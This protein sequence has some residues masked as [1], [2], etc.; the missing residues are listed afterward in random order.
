MSPMVITLALLIL[1]VFV[2][3]V[4]ALQ[5]AHKAA[6]RK[7]NLT[8]I[9]GHAKIK[10]RDGKGRDAQNRRRA[11]IAQKLKEKEPKDHKSGTPTMAQRLQMAG[12]YGTSV[13][14]FWIY[15]LIC[16][17]F[18]MVL[19]FVLK[20]PAP[21]LTVPM[22]GLV[23]LL[24]LPRLFLHRKI[25]SRQQKFLQEFADALEAMVRLLRAGMP[26]S[27]AIR[28]SS[29]EFTGPVGEEMSRIYDA[30]KIG[31]SLPE[32]VQ[33][34]ARRMPI[35]EMQMFA[36]GVTIQQQTG[37]SLSEILTN[38][39]NVI[40]ARFR[41]RRKIQALSAEAKAS[42]MI[43]GSLPFLVGLGM[44]FIN[45]DFM[46][47]LFTTKTGNIMVA[48]GVFWMLCGTFVMKI[49]INFKI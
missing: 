38:L 47:L 39:A 42:A 15:S 33:E 11:E 1:I 29:R 8:V 5:Y 49:M 7:R 23:G 48:F 25:K 32:A 9:R 2:V 3:I 44:F 30:Q 31:V 13:R 43:I 14:S 20:I 34:A 19:A 35:T 12:M 28:M 17:V 26:V 18:V 16:A 36:T 27:E 40:R 6:S 46:M 41:L 21:A 22:I 4:L 24:G 10:M 37:S 45:K